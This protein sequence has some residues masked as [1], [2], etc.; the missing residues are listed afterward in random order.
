MGYGMINNPPDL[1]GC[2]IAGCETRFDSSSPSTILYTIPALD[3]Y[4]YITYSPYQSIFTTITIH[5]KPR[6]NTMCGSQKGCRIEVQ[7]KERR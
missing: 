2:R 4:S 1:D 5:Y 3:P 6:A 7:R